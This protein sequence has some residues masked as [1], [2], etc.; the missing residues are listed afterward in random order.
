MKIAF[1]GTS[2]KST[3]IVEGLHNNF[4]LALCMTK[5]DTKIGRKQKVR[6]T[7]VK[8][9]AKEHGINYLCI[10][11]I[12]E[13]ESAVAKELKKHKIEL[14]VVADFSFI[15]PKSIINTPKYGLINVH[16]SLLPKLRGASPLQHAILQGLRETGVTYYLV[17]EEMDTGVPTLTSRKNLGATF[18]CIRKQPP[19][20][21]NGFIQPV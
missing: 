8:V 6:E 18:L 19:E 1:F 15:I 3:P 20:A 7:A 10:E 13:S 9:W 11:S 14:G 21:G 16:F 12:K 4:D 5:T 17:D 2:D